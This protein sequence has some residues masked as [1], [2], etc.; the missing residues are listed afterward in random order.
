[1]AEVVP[2]GQ[3]LPRALELAATIAEKPFLTRRY[4]RLAL[5]QNI[6]KLLLDGLATGLAFEALA[7][8][9]EWPDDGTMAR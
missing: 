6:R 5:V 2:K 8:V 9:D 3:E 4:T 1:V 7:A